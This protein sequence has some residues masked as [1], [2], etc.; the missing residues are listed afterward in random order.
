ME[1]TMKILVLNGPNLNLLGQREPEIYGSLTLES[2]NRR[3][4]LYGEEL[5]EERAGK[6]S[7]IELYFYQSNH[8]GVLI[9]TI[10]NAPHDYDGIV[11]N[12]AA[13][14]HYS[15]ALRDAVASVPIPV[16]ETHLSD[17][18]ERGSFRMLSVISE[19]CIGQF[20]GKGVDS[21]REAIDL[22]VQYLDTFPTAD[23]REDFASVPVGFSSN[24]LFPDEQDV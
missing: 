2:L 4:A 6:R 16:V 19:V 1:E 13:H 8:E 18:V 21:Y 11:Y 5:N 22:L 15:V 12:P 10:Q 7:R 17:I 24:A 23:E 3:L 9:D 14:T 20:M